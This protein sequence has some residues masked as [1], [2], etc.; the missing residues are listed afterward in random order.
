MIKNKEN[1]LSRSLNAIE[2]IAVKEI[3]EKEYNVRKFPWKLPYP[4]TPQD[5][6]IVREL[7]F[8][9]VGDSS[10]KVSLCFDI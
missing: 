10:S 4:Y 6:I 8:G 1:K 2:N 9:P 3:S 5:I 7:A